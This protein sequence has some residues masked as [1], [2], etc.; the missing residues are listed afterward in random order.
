MLRIPFAFASDRIVEHKQTLHRSGEL[1]MSCNLKSGNRISQISRY[2]VWRTSPCS[3]RAVSFALLLAIFPATASADELPEPTAMS[4]FLA[5]P[6]VLVQV[7]EPHLSTK[8]NPVFVQYRGWPAERV[9]DKWLGQAWRTPGVEI[10]FRALDGYVSHIPYERFQKYSAYLVFE[11]LGQANFSVDNQ[12]QNEKNV[13]LGPYY[14][15]WDNIKDPDL[16]ADG[17]TYWPYQVTQLRVAK[18]RLDTLLPKGMDAR[19]SES[20]ALAQKYCLSC[21]QVNGYGGGKWPVNLAQVAKTLAQDIFMQWILQPS[22]A[23]PGTVM[24]GLPDTLPTIE[25]EAVARKLFEYFKIL[26][27]AY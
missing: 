17:A 9:L 16:L 24:P 5:A 6:P 22:L 13:P 2:L 14:L 8:S 3:L 21:H 10:E 11:R 15:I 26:P 27:V 12:L 23:K 18:A 7:K 4:S 19:Y 20:A 25:R 1:K